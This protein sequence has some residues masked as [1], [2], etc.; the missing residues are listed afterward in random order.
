[1]LILLFNALLWHFVW[2]LSLLSLL[3]FLSSLA[4]SLIA[5][6]A[7][8]AV[9][10]HGVY[11]DRYEDPRPFRNKVSNRLLLSIINGDDD[12]VYITKIN[13]HSI[14]QSPRL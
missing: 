5:K 12:H 10:H 3:S 2:I 13:V 1:M 14:T 8:V 7:H 4:L 6:P 9:A 11:G